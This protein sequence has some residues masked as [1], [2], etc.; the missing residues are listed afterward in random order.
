MSLPIIQLR[1][2]LQKL[3]K[4]S[5][6]GYMATLSANSGVP[7]GT[8]HKIAYDDKQK[9]VTYKVWKQLYDVEPQL[10]PPPSTQPAYRA[11]P[12]YLAPNIDAEDKWF[13]KALQEFFPTDGN[14]KTVEDLALRVGLREKDIRGL[15]IGDVSFIPNEQQKKIIAHGF[16][17]QLD[18][19]IDAGR[20]ILSDANKTTLQRLEIREGLPK[21]SV[22]STTHP[23]IVQIVKMLEK[24]DDEKIRILRDFAFNLLMEHINRD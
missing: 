9:T 13:I 12:D 24:L 17:M 20:R 7:G 10:P 11:E 18:D 16:G 14:F 23:D 1:E 5:E 6:R 15:L 21:Y 4:F 22:A 8:I 3:I 19:F 2:R